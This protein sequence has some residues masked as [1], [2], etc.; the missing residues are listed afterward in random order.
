[1]SSVSENELKDSDEENISDNE[2]KVS[3]KEDGS[4][5]NSDK[6]SEDDRGTECRGCGQLKSKCG[7]TLDECIEA[8]GKRFLSR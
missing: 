5:E 7:L 4:S 3:D 1:M 2:L 6:V 8:V